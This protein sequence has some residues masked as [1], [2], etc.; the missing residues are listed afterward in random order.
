MPKSVVDLADHPL[1]AIQ[2][3]NASGVPGP[4]NA[5]TIENS[6]EFL[7]IEL[8]RASSDRYARLVVGHL[9]LKKQACSRHVR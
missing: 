3:G 6:G 9:L 4:L 5:D 7:H 2:T 8:K 1:P